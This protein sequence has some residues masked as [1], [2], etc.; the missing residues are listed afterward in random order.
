MYVH[1]KAELRENRRFFSTGMEF[2]KN[3]HVYVL[4]APSQS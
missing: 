4:K 3:A 2:A 1:H